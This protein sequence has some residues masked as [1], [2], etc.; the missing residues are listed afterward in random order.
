MPTI[1]EHLRQTSDV[2]ARMA[3]HVGTAEQAAEMIVRALRSGRKVVIFGNGG[4]A[5]DAQ[6]FAAE[7]VGRFEKER[8][9]LPALALTTDTSILTAVGDDYAFDQVYARQVQALVQPGDVAIGLTTSGNS[10]NVLEGI[11]E[12]KRKKAWTVGFTGSSGGK[13]KAAVDI[14]VCVPSSR[15]AHIQECHI[16]LIHSICA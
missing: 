13:L 10:K 5:A 7:L 3:E 15:T 12:A 16:A 9:A 11:Q 14:C 1:S 4:S 8:P 2:L 6:H